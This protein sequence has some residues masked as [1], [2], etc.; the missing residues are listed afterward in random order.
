MLRSCATM[1][2][3]EPQR[4]RG[5]RRRDLSPSRDPC[6]GD[7]TR[8]TRTALVAAI[9]AAMITAP[10]PISATATVVSL[11]LPDVCSTSTSTV[12]AGSVIVTVP[13]GPDCSVPTVGMGC[14]VRVVGGT[15]DADTDPVPAPTRVWLAW[16][17]STMPT[18]RATPPVSKRAPAIHCLP[19]VLTLRHQCSMLRNDSYR[20]SIGPGSTR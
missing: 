9:A 6:A 12:L 4:C 16:L 18:H 14:A 10:A 17:S 11:P 2:P 15:T 20:R 5:A 3:A 19:L 8:A 7:E 1:L 13:G